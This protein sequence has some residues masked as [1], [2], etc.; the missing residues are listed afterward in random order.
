MSKLIMPYFDK[1]LV[2]PGC[3]DQC[4]LRVFNGINNF[5]CVP[6]FA[7]L[8]AQRNLLYV[9]RVLA[10]EAHDAVKAAP[11]LSCA[12]NTLLMWTEDDATFDLVVKLFSNP[13]MEQDDDEGSETNRHH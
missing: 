5:E 7:S 10:A 3:G 12:C 2:C 9:M 6:D 11:N 13:V 4:G 8:V 1:V